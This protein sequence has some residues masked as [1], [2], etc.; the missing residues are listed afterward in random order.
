MVRTLLRN[1]IDPEIGLNIVD[2]GLIYDI[3][4]EDNKCFVLVTMTTIGCPMA[5]AIVNDMY[6]VLGAVGFDDLK[7]E[8]TYTPPWSPEKMTTEGRRILRI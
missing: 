7:V 8:V 2:L 4:I 5:G 6:D 3:K 1:V